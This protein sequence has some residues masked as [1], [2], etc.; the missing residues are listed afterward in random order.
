ML[1]Q[2]NQA[3]KRPHENSRKNSSVADILCISDIFKY[4]SVN[5]N[6]FVQS[7]ASS[8]SD[9]F[10]K[11]SSLLSTFNDTYDTYIKRLDEYYK[12]VNTQLL[13][14]QS[15]TTGLFPVYGNKTCLEGIYDFFLSF[16]IYIHY[17]RSIPD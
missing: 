9:C 8:T 15:P 12:L 4:N 11:E 10:H 6:V 3:D 7:P 2:Q 17:R 5:D 16:S 13:Y 1:F 14:Y